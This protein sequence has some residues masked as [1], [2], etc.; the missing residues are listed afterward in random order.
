MAYLYSTADSSYH[1]VA[2]GMN[3]LEF[4]FYEYKIDIKYRERVEEE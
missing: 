1:Y 2:M 3:R 4:L